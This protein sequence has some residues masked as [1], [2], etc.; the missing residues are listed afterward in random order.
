MRLVAFEGSAESL[1]ACSVKPRRT[2]CTIHLHDWGAYQGAVNP[3]KQYWVRFINSSDQL[4]CIVD[5]GCGGG[6]LDFKTS[7]TVS[8]LLARMA[9]MWCNGN[10][11][12]ELPPSKSLRAA[13]TLPLLIRPAKSLVSLLSTDCGWGLKCSL[14]WILSPLLSKS[15]SYP[16]C[17][18]LR[19][20]ETK[21]ACSIVFDFLFGFCSTSEGR[22]I[23]TL[24]AAD[25]RAESET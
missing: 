21:L 8:F 7:N 25:W 11:P 2:S 9:R 23:T 24:R 10:G 5:T 22:I 20:R 14:F 16:L 12:L 17:H 15:S 4:Y 6:S 13:F 19:R 3:L 18:N 1:P